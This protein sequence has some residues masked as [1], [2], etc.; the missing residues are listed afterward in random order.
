LQALALDAADFGGQ[1]DVACGVGQEPVHLS[2]GKGLENPLLLLKW[3]RMERITVDMT[4]LFKIL[5]L[6]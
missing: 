3:T 5:R 1:G 6:G 2:G 4:I